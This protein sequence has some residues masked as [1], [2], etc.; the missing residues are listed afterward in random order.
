MPQICIEQPSSLVVGHG[1][2]ERCCNFT[3]ARGSVTMVVAIKQ[4]IC[5]FVQLGLVVD[6]VEDVRACI[7]NAIVREHEFASLRIMVVAL[8]NRTFIIFRPD[9]CCQIEP[10]PTLDVDTLGPPF[11][12][13]ATSSDYSRWKELSQ[14]RELEGTFMNVELPAAPRDLDLRNWRATMDE[15]P[16]LRKGFTRKHTNR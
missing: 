2:H 8:P 10:Q 11:A 7:G 15:C 1:I 5:S 4:H 16:N 6:I 3:Y 14:F 9:T 12:I 13:S